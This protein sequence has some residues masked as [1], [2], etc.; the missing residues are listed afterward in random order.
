[1][2]RQNGAQHG[3]TELQKTSASPV[4]TDKALSNNDLI[5]S[6]SGTRTR[7]PGIMSAVL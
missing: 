2:R 6:R 5:N 1:M 4:E 3:A 7:D